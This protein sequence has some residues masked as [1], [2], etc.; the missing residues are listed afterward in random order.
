MLDGSSPRV[1]RKAGVAGKGQPKK[2]AKKS[3]EF[4]REVSGKAWEKNDDRKTIC[5]TNLSKSSEK[6][7]RKGKFRALLANG[8]G[9]CTS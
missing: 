8:G 1:W 6:I 7:E 4:T 3:P 2:I 9:T 5:G